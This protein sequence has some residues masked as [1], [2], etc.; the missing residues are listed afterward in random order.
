MV[1]SE[2]KVKMVDK[3]E[4]SKQDEEGQIKKIIMMRRARGHFDKAR[5]NR[6][7]SI[8]FWSLH[9]NRPFKNYQSEISRYLTISL[10]FFEKNNTSTGHYTIIVYNSLFKDML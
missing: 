5:V 8:T 6:Y 9:F 7:S 3:N 1:I 4:R 2:K 10:F